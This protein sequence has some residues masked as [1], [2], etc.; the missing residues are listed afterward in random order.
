VLS[1]C[2][3]PD[4]SEVFLH[5]NKGKLFCLSPTPDLEAEAKCHNPRL[6]ERFWLCETCSRLLTVV[7]AGTHAKVVPLANANRAK[8]LAL[9][10]VAAGEGRY[11]NPIRHMSDEEDWNRQTEEVPVNPNTCVAK[12]LARVTGLFQHILVAT[13]FSPASHRALGS[14]LSMAVENDSRLSLVHVLQPDWKYATLEN[15]RELD[16]QRIAA[17]HRLHALAGKFGGEKHIET[18]LVECGPV[19][20]AIVSLI[21]K[22]AIDLLIVGSHGH[23]A[24][25]QIALGSVAQELLRMAP[26]P[27][28][29]IGPKADVAAIRRSR[30]F[31]QILYAT[32]FGPGSAKALPVALKLAKERESKM[33]LLHMLAPVP[34]TNGSLS[35]FGPI[36]PGAEELEGWE[37][38]CRTRAIRELK[39]CIPADTELA[40]AP[41]FI[42]GIDFLPEGVLGAARRLNVDL[43]VM[44]ANRTLSARAAAH[45]PWSAVHEVIRSATCPVLTVAG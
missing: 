19:A 12:E 33:I 24:L 2:A 42:A 30:G 23:G 39:S 13:D 44:G 36:V 32:D 5:L 28:M 6:Y 10:A 18:V 4:C 45:I 21:D 41:D 9:A 27:V 17:E 43:I 34:P 8:R 20:A 31:R 25:R 7:W 22:A 15:P 16:T 37:R 11:G 1:K 38:W 26:C 35:A 3:N 29:T 14:A 40:Q